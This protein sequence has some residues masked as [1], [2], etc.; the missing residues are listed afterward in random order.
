MANLSELLNIAPSTLWRRIQDLEG[1]GVIKARVALLDPAK[2][3]C[4]LTVLAAITLTDHSED[5][6]N[7]FSRLI[8]NRAEVG[9][10]DR[11]RW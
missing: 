1:A 6:V 4:K 5:T 11:S 8:A 2:V 3:G 10:I 7:G 9:L